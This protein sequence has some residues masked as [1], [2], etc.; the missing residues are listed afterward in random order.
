[1]KGSLIILALVLGLAVVLG[2]VLITLASARQTG[3]I[4]VQMPPMI[5]AQAQ[6]PMHQMTEQM[7]RQMAQMGITVKALHAQLNKINPELLT[8]QERPMYEYLKTLQTHLE[9][10]HGMMGTMQRMMIQMPG[11]MK[12]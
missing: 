9:T 8:G 4:P 3:Q 2:G 1:M 5:A 10:M 11:R 12:R 7:Q 6:M